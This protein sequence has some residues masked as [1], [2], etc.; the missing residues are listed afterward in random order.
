MGL[1]VMKATRVP[2]QYLAESLAGGR[3]SLGVKVGVEVGATVGLMIILTLP[4]P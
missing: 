3:R 4:L 1:R 2:A